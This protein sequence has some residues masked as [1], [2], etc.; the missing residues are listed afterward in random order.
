MGFRFLFSS[1]GLAAAVGCYT[2]SAVDTTRPPVVTTNGTDPTGG[3]AKRAPDKTTGIPCGVSEILIESCSDCHGSQLVGT[4]QRLLTY[5]DLSAKTEDDPSQT[6]AARAVVRMRATDKPM[7]PDERLDDGKIAAFDAWIK[8]GLPRGSCGEGV[9]DDGGAPTPSPDGG[10]IDAG[11]ACTSGHYGTDSSSEA[12]LMSPGKVCIACHSDKGAT[13]LFAAGT[14]YPTLHEPDLCKGAW[15]AN[16]SVIL[17][18]A[19]GVSHTVSVNA[20]GNFVRYTSFPLPYRALVV[21]GTDVREMNT[22]QYD[23]DCNACHSK[24]GGD[25]APGRIVAP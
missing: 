7:P 19:D 1:I 16:L 22:P 4:T 21:R 9:A 2:G 24:W 12:E 25:D 11:S 8:A 23:G 17:I 14:V 20:A 18:D 5:E 13:S 3:T 10:D 6:V 15:N